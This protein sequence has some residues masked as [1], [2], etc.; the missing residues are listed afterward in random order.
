MKPGKD[1]ARGSLAERLIATKGRPS[2]FDYLRLGLAD[3]GR[4]HAQ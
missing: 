2:G 1:V 4:P 3:L